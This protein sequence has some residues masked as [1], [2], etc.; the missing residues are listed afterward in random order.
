ML[1]SKDTNLTLARTRS[2]SGRSSRIC[3]KVTGRAP[4]AVRSKYF[5]W[6]GVPRV[7]HTYTF[8]S[9][10][11]RTNHSCP[12][13]APMLL[14]SATTKNGKK[15]PP[16]K[17][18]KQ[19]SCFDLGFAG[20]NWKYQK[21]AKL[22]TMKWQGYVERA[23]SLWVTFHWMTR[24]QNSIDDFAFT[25]SWWQPQS[26]DILV[27]RELNTSTVITQKSSAHSSTL[28]RKCSSKPRVDLGT[29][30]LQPHGRLTPFPD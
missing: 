30:T 16:E 5:I 1:R 14:N 29:E 23:V 7:L 27:V 12:G 19:K 26:Q 3:R 13:G 20:V 10:S 15:K 21:K 9:T 17:T 28:V 22:L 18:L 11:P 25:F 4:V 2:F 24:A 6:L 8:T